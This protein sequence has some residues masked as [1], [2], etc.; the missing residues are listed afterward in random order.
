M[1][2]KS[3]TSLLAGQRNLHAR[4]SRRAD[5]SGRCETPEIANPSFISLISGRVCM[6][7]YRAINGEIH[8]NLSVARMTR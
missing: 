7:S 8:G 1:S 2:A 6:L 5:L 3:L 4:S